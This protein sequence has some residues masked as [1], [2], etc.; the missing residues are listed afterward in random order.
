MNMPQLIARQLH[1]V[2]FGG[3][4]TTTNLRDTV[5]DVTWQ[6]AIAQ[7]H[8]LNT[9]AT[10][11]Y[12]STYFVT[13]LLE[14]LSDKPLNASDKLSFVHPPITCDEDWQNL[15]S[16]AWEN[17]QKT[18]LLLEQLPEG[19][20]A[21]NFSGDKYG[22]YYRNIAGITEHLHYHLGQIVIIKKLLAE[23]GI[24]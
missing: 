5:Q 22:S 17:A 20:L 6:Q 9:I 4:W 19:K 14:V 11:T 18:V 21:E 12:H 23:Q 3:N 16:T 1:E 13:A 8:G 10:L 15:L 24:V 7:V 2:Y